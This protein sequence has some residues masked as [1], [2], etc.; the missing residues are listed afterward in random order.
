MGHILTHFSG[1]RDVRRILTGFGPDFSEAGPE[2]CDRPEEFGTSTPKEHTIMNPARKIAIGAAMLG[3]TM[4]GGALGASMFSGI[5]SAQTSSNSSSSSAPAAPAQ[6][7][8]SKGGH[9]AN[10]ITEQVLT[11]DTATKVTAAAQAAVPDGTVQRVE[12]D[13]EGAAY[14]AHM[15]K[16]DGSSVTVKLN[17]DFTVANIVDGMG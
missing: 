10:G 9:T 1:T 11:G 14:E 3:A 16:A 12:T 2:G 6:P 4:T 8:P 13:A 17:S 5:A 7:D 15:T